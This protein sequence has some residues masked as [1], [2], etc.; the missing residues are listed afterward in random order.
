M[1]APFVGVAPRLALLAA[2]LASV[3]TGV[4]GQSGSARSIVSEG[5]AKESRSVYTG[6]LRGT[7]YSPLDQITLPPSETSTAPG[8]P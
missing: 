5:T 6:D 8:R 7:R 3:A 4:P 2:A 1:P